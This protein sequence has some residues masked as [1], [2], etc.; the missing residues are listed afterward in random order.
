MRGARRVRVERHV[1]PA[2]LEDR[3]AARRPGPAPRSRHEADPGLAPATPPAQVVRQLVGARVQLAVGQRLAS[4]DDRHRLRRARRLRL[5]EL[6]DA[7]R[8]R[9]RPRG[10]VPL[11]EQ[12]PALLRVEQRQPADRAAPGSPRSPPS[13][14]RKCAAIRAIVAASNRSVLYSTQP[15][16]PSAAL[17]RANSVRSNLRRR[18][19]SGRP[20][21]TASPGQLAACGRRVL[22]REHHLE[23]RIAAE[24]ARRAQLLDQLLERQV[25]V[26]VGVE[27]QVCARRRATR[28]KAGRPRDRRAAPAC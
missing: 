15:R 6:V 12:P 18:R 17:R 24:V 7:A 3:R 21:S 25:L 8:R 13:S 2:R 11:D 1:G 28:V 9:D 23:Q 16:K 26:R 20:R 4:R 10:V 5:E 27:R 22:Q 19:E 14:V